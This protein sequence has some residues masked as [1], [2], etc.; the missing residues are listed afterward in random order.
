MS[1]PPLIRAVQLFDVHMLLELLSQEAD[2]NCTTTPQGKT[3]LMVAVSHPSKSEREEEAR[4]P[5]IESL[6]KAGAQ[7]GLKDAEGR[8]ASDLAILTQRVS[9][10]VAR[11]LHMKLAGVVVYT[12]EGCGY[13]VAMKEQGH[14]IGMLMVHVGAKQPVLSSGKT[15]TGYPCTDF[16]RGNVHEGFL[17]ISAAD[18]RPGLYEAFLHFAQLEQ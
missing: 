12:M 13:C 16:G 1:T 11:V 8:T 18:K 6:V 17:T 10:D 4:L 7:H 14:G 9:A 5:L 3:A 15:P 2:V